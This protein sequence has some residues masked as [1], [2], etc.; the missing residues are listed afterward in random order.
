MFISFNQV[1]FKT[2]YFLKKKVFVAAFFGKLAIC[3]ELW[4]WG[5]FTVMYTTVNAH[6]RIENPSRYVHQMYTTTTLLFRV[7][8]YPRV[9]PRVLSFFKEILKKNFFLI[10]SFGTHKFVCPITTSTNRIKG[11]IWRTFVNPSYNATTHCSSWTS[12]EFATRSRMRENS[13]IVTNW[14]AIV[15]YFHLQNS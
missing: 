2:F 15:K 6:I 12:Y 10:S 9:H 3:L 1:L 11:Q 14:F 8:F 5:Y 7:Y 4:L 13:N